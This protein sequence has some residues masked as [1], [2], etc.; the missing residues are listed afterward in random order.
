MR[1]EHVSSEE[2]TWRSQMPKTM[3]EVANVIGRARGGTDMVV[4]WRS[5]MPHRKVAEGRTEKGTLFYIHKFD[6]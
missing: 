6:G 2:G 4:G 1:I 5:S 3:R